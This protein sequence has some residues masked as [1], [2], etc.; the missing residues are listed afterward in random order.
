MGSEGRRGVYLFEPGALSV[1][2][3]ALVRSLALFSGF[4]VFL[5]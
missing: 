4:L 1:I 3:S 2:V 5:S